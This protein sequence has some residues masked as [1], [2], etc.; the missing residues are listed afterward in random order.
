MEC[1]GRI[2]MTGLAIVFWVAGP[3]FITMSYG[4]ENPHDWWNFVFGWGLSLILGGI[5]PIWLI[6]Q[7]WN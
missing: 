1:I 3:L 5:G 4:D 2:A 6:V 7:V